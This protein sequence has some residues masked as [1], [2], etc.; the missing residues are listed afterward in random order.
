[1]Q[2][3]EISP[4]IVVEQ[5]HKEKQPWQY[6]YISSNWD[7]HKYSLSIAENKRIRIK[8]GNL[9]TTN[10]LIK[11]ILIRSFAFDENGFMIHIS[12]HIFA[13]MNIKFILKSFVAT[14]I[15]NV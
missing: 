1:M 11:Y 10:N 8:C 12:K 13:N 3:F 4:S 9:Q 2:N 5:F 15:S 6:I 14:D 7:S